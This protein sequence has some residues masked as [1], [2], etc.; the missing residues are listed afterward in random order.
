MQ[1]HL[2]IKCHNKFN[3]LAF[4][5][6]AV[7]VRYFIYSIYS[8]RFCWNEPKREP[9]NERK[10]KKQAQTVEINE[11]SIHFMSGYVCK[12]GGRGKHIKLSSAFL[13]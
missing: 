9:K 6:W 13:N 4:S 1:F 2:Y 7:A 11:K 5:L 10:E 3:H 8:E 12:E